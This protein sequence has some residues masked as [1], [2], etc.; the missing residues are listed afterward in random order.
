[1]L[2]VTATAD[3]GEIMGLQHRSKPQFGVQFHPES[4]ASEEGGRLLRAFLG[5][6]RQSDGPVAQPAKG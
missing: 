1:D 3:D 6:A 4:I 2:E 5:F